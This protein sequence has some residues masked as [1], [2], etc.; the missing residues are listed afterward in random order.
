MSSILEI[1]LQ[2]SAS[3]FPSNGQIKRDLILVACLVEFSALSNQ[4]RVSGRGVQYFDINFTVLVSLSV[5][6][7]PIQQPNDNAHLVLVPIDVSVRSRSGS[8][9]L[10]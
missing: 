5:Q 9:N 4:L 7:T 6:R 3:S 10:L 8:Q 2:K 1:F